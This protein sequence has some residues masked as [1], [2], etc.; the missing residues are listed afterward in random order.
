MHNENV[1]AALEVEVEVECE[2]EIE[3]ARIVNPSAVV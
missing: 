1:Y 2:A 3:D